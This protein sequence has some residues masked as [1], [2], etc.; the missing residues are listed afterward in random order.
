MGST[1]GGSWHGMAGV[2]HLPALERPDEVADIVC[3]FLTRCSG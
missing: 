2:A 3:D 1:P